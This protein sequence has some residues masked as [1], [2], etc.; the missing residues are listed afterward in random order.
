[1]TKIAGLSGFLLFMRMFFFNVCNIDYIC[2]GEA[3]YLCMIHVFMY[4]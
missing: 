3:R 1:L 4:Y 2:D